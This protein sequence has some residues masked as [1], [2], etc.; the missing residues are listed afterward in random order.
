[1]RMIL[2]NFRNKK[3]GKGNRNPFDRSKI[4]LARLGRLFNNQRMKRGNNLRNL[5][6]DEGLILK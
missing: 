5:E 6:I 2:D 4:L 3:V 1:M